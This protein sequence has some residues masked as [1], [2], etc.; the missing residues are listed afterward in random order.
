[1]RAKDIIAAIEGFAPASIQESWDN[2]GLQIGSPDQEVKGVL[3]ALDCTEKLVRE[4]VERGCDMIVTHHPLIF[5]PLCSINPDDT[6]GATVMA[7]IKAGIAVYASHTSSDKVPGGV[8]GEMARKL[9]LLNI[10]ILCEDAPG[11]GLGAVGE[12]PEPLSAAEAV[13]LVK[14]SFGL[15][16]LRTSALIPGQVKTIAMCGGSG[17]SLIPDA[18]AAGAQM[19]LC[20]DISY[21]NFFVPEGFM[22]ADVGHF[23]S[24]VQ[25]VETLHSVI[26]KNFPNFASLISD[27][28]GQANPVNYL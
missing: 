11:V 23:E 18:I 26:R 25:I 28:I 16:V 21:H 12:L 9:G 13:A 2:T 22:L 15:P 20:G 4:A 19:Y 10:R 24:E 6:V 8:S 27:F 1:M 7:A 17:S 5:H 14:K 3:L